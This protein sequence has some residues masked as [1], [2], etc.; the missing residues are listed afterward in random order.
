M[1]TPVMWIL[2][3]HSLGAEVLASLTLAAAWL[4]LRRTAPRGRRP[5]HETGRE[6]AR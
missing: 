3:P 4:G 6:K 2:L 1:G 5:R